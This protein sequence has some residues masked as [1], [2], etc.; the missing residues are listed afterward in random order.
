M[1]EAKFSKKYCRKELYVYPV[2]YSIGNG[3][4]NIDKE[5]EDLNYIIRTNFKS[6]KEMD[7]YER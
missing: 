7:D 3:M 5:I 2:Y 4:M 6:Q 1:Q